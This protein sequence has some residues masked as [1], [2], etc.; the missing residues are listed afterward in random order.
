MAYDAKLMHVPEIQ[1]LGVFLSDLE[2]YQLPDRCFLC[3]TPAGA[4]DGSVIIIS[5]L[6]FHKLTDTCEQRRGR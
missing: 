5:Y 1:W 2:E 6:C 4:C 3:L